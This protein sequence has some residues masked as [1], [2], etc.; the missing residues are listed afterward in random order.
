MINAIVYVEELEKNGFS[1][2]QA[3][4]A[5]KIWMKLMNQNFATKDDLN[6]GLL[7]T[8][9]EL[10]EE[11]G[12]VRSELKEEIGAVRSELKEEIGALRLEFK[13]ELRNEI[14]ALRSEFKAD[15]HRL[16]NNI[17]VLGSKIDN[18]EQGLTIKLSKVIVITVTLASTF[19][20]LITKM[21]V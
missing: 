3:S 15:I 4:S 5:V 17:V 10:K 20:G 13:S 19:V 8:R 11:I 12:A 7:A 14:G 16:D 21:I 1:K 9:S 18:I 2:G 6:I